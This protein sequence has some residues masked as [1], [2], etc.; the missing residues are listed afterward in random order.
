MYAEKSRVPGS[1]I[2]AL[3]VALLAPASS[4]A[5]TADLAVS[6][7]DSPDPIV[8]G[9]AAH[10]HGHDRESR[11]G[12]RERGCREERAVEPRHVRLGHGVARHV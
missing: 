8:E 9:A 12:D 6:T 2:A 11:A 7:T 1:V 4:Q 10:L 5:A 3:A